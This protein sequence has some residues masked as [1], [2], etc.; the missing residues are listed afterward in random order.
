MS[1]IKGVE[2]EIT[3][4]SYKTVLFASGGLGFGLLVAFLLS[5]IFSRLG[6][7]PLVFCINIILYM[8]CIYLGLAVAKK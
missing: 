7:T 3:Q 4:A 2:R 8:I 6:N 1:F 5:T